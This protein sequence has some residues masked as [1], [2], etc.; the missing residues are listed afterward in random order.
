MSNDLRIDQYTEPP[1]GAAAAPPR[2]AGGSVT[3]RYWAGAQAA[4][5]VAT[6]DLPA[7]SV[8]EI[9]AAASARHPD[10]VAVLGVCAVLV[11]GIAA[12]PDTLVAPG[13]TIEFLPP[14]AGG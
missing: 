1:L 11:D 14:F 2:E 4:A 6:E 10:A 5:G 13:A 8:A 7:G 12:T 3:A 9:V